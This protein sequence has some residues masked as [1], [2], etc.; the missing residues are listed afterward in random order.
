MCILVSFVHV[1]FFNISIKRHSQLKDVKLV[2]SFVPDGNVRL[3]VSNTY[4]RWHSA[5]SWCLMSL[6][7][8]KYCEFCGVQ[9]VH[10]IV[11]NVVMS[12]GEAFSVEGHLADV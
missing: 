3:Q 11:H 6:Y 4:L 10:H 7:V 1:P 5:P 8:T 2:V 9:A 12:P